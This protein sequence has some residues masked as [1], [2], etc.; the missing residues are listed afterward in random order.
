MPRGFSLLLSCCFILGGVFEGKQ[1]GE[2]W[3]EDAKVIVGGIQ[4]LPDEA[5]R[6]KNVQLPVII[7][8]IKIILVNNIPGGQR[9]NY[10]FKRLPFEKVS[11]Q[12]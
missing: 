7:F 1:A 3:V 12:N 10:P 9:P 6:E 2:C 4:Q 8:L 5:A 11:E